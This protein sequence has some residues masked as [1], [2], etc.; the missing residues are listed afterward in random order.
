MQECRCEEKISVSFTNITPGE[1]RL[2]MAWLRAAYVV[3]YEDG[4]K[5][6]C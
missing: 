4:R 1:Q 2:L 5:E 6:R 3:G